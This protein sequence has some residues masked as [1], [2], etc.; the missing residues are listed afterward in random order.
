VDKSDN[1]VNQIDPS[2][3][4]S[5]RARSEVQVISLVLNYRYFSIDPIEEKSLFVFVT[6]CYAPINVMSGSIRKSLLISLK[7]NM[8]VI[9]IHQMQKD[10]TFVFL[11]EMGQ[12]FKEYKY[13]L[14]KVRLLRR[15]ST[16]Q[17]ILI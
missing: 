11:T 17:T 8:K 1:A 4:G 15:M 2:F 5:L 13:L 3:P 7:N 10:Y 12:Q 6:I 16:K 14:S 9:T